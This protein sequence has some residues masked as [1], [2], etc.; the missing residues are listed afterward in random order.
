MLGQSINTHVHASF[1]DSTQSDGNS[2]AR[3]FRGGWTL[4]IVGKPLKRN[5]V[6][7]DYREITDLTLSLDLK[8]NLNE[9]FVEIY[10]D[11]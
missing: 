1:Y 5:I 11:R 2:A 7:I 10:N 9:T 8:H 4:D 3:Y 6:S